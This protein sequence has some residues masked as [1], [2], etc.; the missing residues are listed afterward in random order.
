MW[1]MGTRL[2]RKRKEQEA[3]EELE[4]SQPKKEYNYTTLHLHDINKEIIYKELDYKLK[5]NIPFKKGE[6]NAELPAKKQS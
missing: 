4:L 2:E 5:H 3:K 1:V 6:S